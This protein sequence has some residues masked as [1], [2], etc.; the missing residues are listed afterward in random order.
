MEEAQK[1]VTIDNDE[2]RPMHDYV[3]QIF[4]MLK[5]MCKYADGLSVD[6]TVLKKRIVAKGFTEDQLNDTIENYLRMN[7][8]MR[9][10]SLLTLIEG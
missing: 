2:R 1:S 7:I 8:I 5:E 4:E 6:Y 3:S 10:D 9:E